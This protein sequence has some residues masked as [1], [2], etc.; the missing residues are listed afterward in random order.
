VADQL[1]KLLL[2]LD[3]EVI[4]RSREALSPDHVAEFWPQA[5][6]AVMREISPYRAALALYDSGPEAAIRLADGI[7][8]RYPPDDENVAWAH[9]LRGARLLDSFQYSAAEKEFR[10]VVQQADAAAPRVSW[11]PFGTP[12][13]SYAEPAH[14]YLGLTL[15][16][17]G[18]PDAASVEL[19]K[20]LR[21]DPN[22]PAAHHYLGLAATALKQ[23][24]EAS[25]HSRPHARDTIAYL[26]GSLTRTDMA[27]GAR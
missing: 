15:L 23:T 5:A 3:G 21:L 27:R 9:L 24:A 2:R 6:E 20:A 14:F 4:F 13:V 8:R 17:L 10:V 7:I 25:V 22:D 18:Q 16:D 11:T 26:R 12:L 1:L 19:Q